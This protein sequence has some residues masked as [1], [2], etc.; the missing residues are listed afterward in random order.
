MPDAVM[1]APDIDADDI[2]LVVQVLKSG[3]LS[4]GPFLERFEQTFADYIGTR[5]AIAVNSG[6][7][8]LHLCLGAA[9]VGPATRSSPRRSAS[10]P[11]PT[12]HL[13]G[14]EAGLRRHRPDHP[15]DRPRTGGVASRPADPR[16]PPGRRL[17]A[18]GR[19][20]AI[21]AIADGTAWRSCRGRLRG[22]R[23]RASRPSGRLRRRRRRLR[24]LPEQADDHGR[25]GD[26]RHR[27]RR[28]RASGPEH[29][30]PGPRRRRHLDEPRPARL[31]LPARRDER[32]ARALAAGPP[33][34]GC[35]RA[36]A[37]V[38]TT[39]CRHPRAMFPASWSLSAPVDTTVAPE[40]VRRCIVR[41]DERI[42][43]RAIT[44]LQ[45]LAGPR[46]TDAGL[47]PGRS[48][49]SPTSPRRS[50]Y[51]RRGFSGRRARRQRHAGAAVSFQHV[52]G[53]HRA[54]RRSSQGRGRVVSR[55]GF[56]FT[57]RLI[58][59][60]RMQAFVVFPDTVQRVS[61]APLIRDRSERRMW[62]GPGSTAHH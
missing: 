45:H 27:R 22:D 51:R 55:P 54:H 24:L 7:S 21:D 1:S 8:G 60:C 47:F 59:G 48:T 15:D 42:F 38:A 62:N 5:H 23:R 61:V 12:V 39:Y 50:G 53:R 56:A 44:S 46:D 32:R 43:D 16:D 57:Q 31:Q 33:R 6:T 17:R 36:A 40:L 18:D 30:Q 37:K 41:L 49:S 14:G 29:E 4:I 9:G 58:V 3:R 28:L 52:R 19:H 2:E 20:R 26:G 10:S 25:G 34:P 11:R 13:S 35:W